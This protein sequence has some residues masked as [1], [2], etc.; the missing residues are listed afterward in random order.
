MTQITNISRKNRQ[1]YG[2]P[3]MSRMMNTPNVPNKDAQQRGRDKNIPILPNNYRSD[4]KRENHIAN[5]ST[6]FLIWTAK[7]SQK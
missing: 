6:F 4:N 1:M 5:I 2:F 3:F 7:K